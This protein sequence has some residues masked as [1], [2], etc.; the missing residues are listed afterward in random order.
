MHVLGIDAGGTKTVCLLADD[1]GE[2][3][4]Q[5]RAS[6]ANL[7]VMG[8]FGVEKILHRIMD[9]TLGDRD[10]KLDAIC[11]GI[12]GVDRPRDAQAIK[13]VM[14]RI[15][16]KT[17]TIVVNDALVALVAGA[18]DQAGVVV[19]AGTG[20][21]AYGRDTEGRAA[22]AGGWGYLLGDEGGG[23]W[24]GRAALSAVVRQFD[25][26][27]PATL[28]T[29]LVLAQM[30]LSTPAE[31]I[32]AIYDRGLQR[33]AI[34]G[35]AGVVQRA[36]E[37]GDAVAGEILDRAAIELAAAAA[38]VVTRLGMRGDVFPTVLA[39]G[40]F[41][42]IPSLVTSVTT[43]LAEVAPRSEVRRLEIEPANGAVTLAL[44]AARG[45]VVIPVYI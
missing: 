12:A 38:S 23:F 29:D 1:R 35:L 44:A 30:Q 14:R 11:L 20:S 36:M 8:E 39:G 40:M 7:Q 16:Q 45:Q 27:G 19:V 24:I 32:H 43:R 4:A 5:A 17:L 10:I 21:I 41:K 28:L 34:A 37:A 6:G 31:V 25:Q 18:G 9:E 15:G 13:E 33:H 26:R 2:V 42:G 22:R 3:L